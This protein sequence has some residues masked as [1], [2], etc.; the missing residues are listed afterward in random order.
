MVA[1]NAWHGLEEQ[2]P[3]ASEYPPEAVWYWVFVPAAGRVTV[4]GEQPEDAW[5]V[6]GM[7]FAGIAVGATEQ[8]ESITLVDGPELATVIWIIWFTLAA[9]ENEPELATLFLSPE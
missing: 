4:T 1:E 7:P 6:C 9:M 3:M 5:T 8:P 2:V